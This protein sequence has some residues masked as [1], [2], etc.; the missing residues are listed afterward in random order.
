MKSERHHEEAL[1]TIILR[2][3]ISDVWRSRVVLIIEKISSVKK[4]NVFSSI[5]VAVYQYCSLKDC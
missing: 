1:L 4:T 3:I 2:P 5:C